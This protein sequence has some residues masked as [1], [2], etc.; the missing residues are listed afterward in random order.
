MGNKD[1]VFPCHH[2]W[3]SNYQISLFWGCVLLECLVF[4]VTVSV[5]EFHFFK[6]KNHEIG[7]LVWD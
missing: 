5:A 1:L 4:K 6:K 3:V 2:S 7:N